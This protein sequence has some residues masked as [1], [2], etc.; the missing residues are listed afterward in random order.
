MTRACSEKDRALQMDKAFH[1][2]AN[3]R[4][5]VLVAKPDPGGKAACQSKISVAKNADGGLEGGTQ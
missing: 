3:L 5:Q 4:L 2:T 1:E